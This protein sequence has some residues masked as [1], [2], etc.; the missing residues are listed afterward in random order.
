MD[1]DGYQDFRKEGRLI[2]GRDS[3]GR[4]QRPPSI[5]WH[6]YECLS[7]PD[8]CASCIWREKSDACAKTGTYED[9]YVR[10]SDGE[11]R[12]AER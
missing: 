9:V 10:G 3:G 4:F 1:C 8:S 5:Y 7:Y 2:G 11:Y 12:K 6:K